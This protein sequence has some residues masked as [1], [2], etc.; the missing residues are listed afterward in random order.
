MGA[1]W[2][3]APTPMDIPA[4]FKNDR[5]PTGFL[6]RFSFTEFVTVSITELREF[7]FQKNL[8]ALKQGTGRRSLE[9]LKVSVL[10]P[11]GG[12]EEKNME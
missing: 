9:F 8:R 5:R 7:L 10:S 3:K 1:T 6:I 2:Y 11:Q 4:I 12:K